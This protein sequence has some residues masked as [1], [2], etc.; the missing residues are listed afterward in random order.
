MGGV[1]HDMHYIHIKQNLRNVEK[2]ARHKRDI[3]VSNYWCHT[4]SEERL[5]D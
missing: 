2:M 1:I 3:I 5:I 4:T